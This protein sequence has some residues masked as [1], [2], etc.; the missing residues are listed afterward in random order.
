VPVPPRTK[1]RLVGI[2][3]VEWNYPLVIQV[4]QYN[5]EHSLKWDQGDY[6]DRF[7]VVEGQI[8]SSRCDLIWRVG[9]CVST[10]QLSMIKP[11]LI[12]R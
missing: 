10:A 3:M 6:I 12:L 5:S 8:L 11:S 9:E 1:I 4:Y 2:S 7:G